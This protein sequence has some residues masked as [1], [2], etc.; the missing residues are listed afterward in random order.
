[1]VEPSESAQW[2]ERARAGERPAFDALCAPYVD[3]ARALAY[4]IVRDRGEAE[5]VV[6]DALLAAWEHLAELREPSAFGG[7]LM[8]SVKNRSVTRWQRARTGNKA[9][10][11]YAAEPRDVGADPYMRFAAA[12][13]ASLVRRVLDKL[14][15]GDARTAVERYY[16]NEDDHGTIAAALGVPKSTVTTWLDRARQRL[17]KELVIELTRR[18]RPGSDS[19]DITE[20]VP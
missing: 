4:A 11:D 7:W 10:E 17:R 1:M 16:V 9:R 20:V 5:D 6:Q 2:V 3:Q 14:P 15:L 19:Q 12:Q 13:R 18:R 8:R